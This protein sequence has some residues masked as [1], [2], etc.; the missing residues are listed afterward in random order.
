MPYNSFFNQ[1]C[2][3]PNR[4]EEKHQNLNIHISHDVAGSSKYKVQ[5][6]DMREEKVNKRL[7][8]R[9]SLSRTIV[10]VYFYYKMF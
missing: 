1:N 9:I 4:L 10:L 5:K 3:S 6:V 8:G 2:I 7:M